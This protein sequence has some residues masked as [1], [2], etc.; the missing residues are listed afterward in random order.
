M[1]KKKTK[2]KKLWMTAARSTFVTWL[3]R[4]QKLVAGAH[5]YVVIG[6]LT[7]LSVNKKKNKKKG[8]A[9]QPINGREYIY[10]YIKKMSIYIL[11]VKYITFDINMCGARR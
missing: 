4:P 2:K 8:K 10:I 11:Y 6:V 9:R 7:S 5:K 1:I 3:P